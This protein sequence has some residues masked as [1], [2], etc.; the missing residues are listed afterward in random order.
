MT[1]PG[2][3]IMKSVGILSL[4]LL[5]HLAISKECLV[6]NE[7]IDGIRAI[8]GLDP[9]VPKDQIHYKPFTGS[10]S[11]IKSDDDPNLSDTSYCMTD[12]AC[13]HWEAYSESNV[14]LEKLACNKFCFIDKQSRK[15]VQSELFTIQHPPT[16][17]LSCGWETC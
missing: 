1:L 13:G 5:P 16:H 17:Y 4:L 6:G 3:V 8:I 7:F 14:A 15:Y 10:F 9:S 12:N 2:S 11:T